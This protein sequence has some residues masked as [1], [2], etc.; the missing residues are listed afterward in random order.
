MSFF[1][2]VYF[3][4]SSFLLSL[5][6]AHNGGKNKVHIFILASLLVYTCLHLS[7]LRSL[8]VFLYIAFKIGPMIVAEGILAIVLNKAYVQEEAKRH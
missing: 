3:S 6:F 8:N 1:E 5:S 2:F 4:F 7:K